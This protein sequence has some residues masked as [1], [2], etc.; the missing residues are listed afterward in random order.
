MKKWG[1]KLPEHARLVSYGNTELTLYN[2]PAITV[3]DCKY[4]Q[5]AEK[6]AQLI[7]MGKETGSY[8]Q[9]IIQ[10]ELIIRET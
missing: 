8:E 5:M 6:T 4:E 7:A 3:I 10:P 1:I 2:E 9:H